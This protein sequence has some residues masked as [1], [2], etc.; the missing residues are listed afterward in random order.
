[1][2]APLS[3]V[4]PIFALNFWAY[5][6]GCQYLVKSRGVS[7][8]DGL[9]L[10]DIGLAGAVAAIPTTVRHPPGRTWARASVGA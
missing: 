2:V 5:D 8:I 6:A 10:M 7:S 4:T 9:S 3:G 1:M